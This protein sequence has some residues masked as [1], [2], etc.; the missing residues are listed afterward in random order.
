MHYGTEINASQFGVKGLGLGLT[1]HGRIKCA[2]NSTFWACEN[3]VLKSISWIFATFTPVM[4]YGTEV[5]TLNFGV[6][7]SHSKVMME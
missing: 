1:C 7:R 6:R 2:G 4:Y 5:K 3:N